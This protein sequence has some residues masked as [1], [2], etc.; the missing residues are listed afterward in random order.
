[1]N[2]K[3]VAGMYICLISGVSL[4]IILG[5]WFKNFIMN[6]TKRQAG[7]VYKG[8]ADILGQL[9]VVGLGL[10]IFQDNP[11]GSLF[12]ISCVCLSL[13]IRRIK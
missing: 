10:G 7:E 12:G 4:P 3:L 6:T 11:K 13:I 8:I 1:M 5:I 2:I 9:G